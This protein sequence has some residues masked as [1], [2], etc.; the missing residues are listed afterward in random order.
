MWPRRASERLR[1]CSGVRRSDLSL[2]MAQ[3]GRWGGVLN[4][5]EAI[6]NLLPLLLV[7]RR[8]GKPLERLRRQR[9][10]RLGARVRGGARVARLRQHTGAVALK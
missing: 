7:C 3:G 6:L 1:L 5:V 2:Q 4:R 10:E 8:R 9:L